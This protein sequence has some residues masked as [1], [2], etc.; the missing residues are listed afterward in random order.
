M[1]VFDANG[2]VN[3]DRCHPCQPERIDH[4]IVDEVSNQDFLDLCRSLLFDDLTSIDELE[5]R[6]I[7]RKIAG[8]QDSKAI[9]ALG[10]QCGQGYPRSALTIRAIKVSDFHQNVSRARSDNHPTSRSVQTRGAT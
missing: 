3:R 1:F 5:G 10:A 2:R 9:L 7:S 8:A 6:S 4:G